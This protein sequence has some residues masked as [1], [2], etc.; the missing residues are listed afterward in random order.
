MTDIVPPG[1]APLTTERL[2]LRPFASEDAAE[3]H[4]LINDWEVCRNLA[5]V[6]F[7]YPRDLADE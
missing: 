1:F 3:L 2:S 6:P 4:R 5:A 7:P